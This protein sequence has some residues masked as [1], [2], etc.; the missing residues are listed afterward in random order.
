MMKRLMLCT[1]VL[2]GAGALFAEDA[3][4]QSNG[5]NT[6]NTGYYAS[7]KT[8]IAV[9][10]QMT[11]IKSGNDCL[12]GHYNAGATVTCLIYCPNTTSIFAELKD[13]THEGYAKMFV[14]GSTTTLAGSDTKRHTMVIDAPGER[15]DLYDSS[16]NPEAYYE[17]PK[18]WTYNNTSTWPLL[19]FGASADT[20]EADSERVPIS[21]DSIVGLTQKGPFLKGSTV[22][23]YE[24]SDGRTLKQTNGNFTSKI[25]SDDGRYKFSARDLVSQYAMVVVDGYY[26]NE[27]TG[28][29]SDAPIRLT[30]LTDRAMADATAFLSKSVPL[31]PQWE[32]ER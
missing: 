30:A 3:Y 14:S 29:T 28:G 8:K 17:F 13:G 15:A 25:T 26:R 19:L 11:E 4:I 12:I 32:P 9:D 31:P 7:G 10:F 22:Y 27:V 20:A 24:L 1:M 16:G 23:L 21:L 5:A 6:I 18:S 2:M